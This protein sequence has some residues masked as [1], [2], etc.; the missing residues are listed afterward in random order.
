MYCSGAGLRSLSSSGGIGSG[1]YEGSCK[2][3]SLVMPFFNQGSSTIHYCGKVSL[4]T[5]LLKL[6]RNSVVTCGDVVY[7]IYQSAEMLYIISICGDV[8]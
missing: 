8:F 5:N 6:G 3:G 1:L 4:L 2:F 7:N